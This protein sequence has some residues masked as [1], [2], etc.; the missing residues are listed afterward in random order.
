MCVV[1]IVYCHLSSF[2]LFAVEVLASF[3]LE[4]EGGR[5]LLEGG[6]GRGWGQEDY[7]GVVFLCDG[8]FGGWH[9]KFGVNLVCE[10]VGLFSIKAVTFCHAR[11][12]AASFLAATKFSL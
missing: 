7:L 3:G 8:G 10:V 4:E 12:E 5:D 1:C 9:F 6:G 11:P 2:S